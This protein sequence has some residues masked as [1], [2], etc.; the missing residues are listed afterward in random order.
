MSDNGPQFVSHVFKS[1]CEANG[2]KHTMVMPYHPQSNGTAER[3][4]QTV[5]QQTVGNET[6]AFG[7]HF[8]SVFPLTDILNGYV[9]NTAANIYV[10]LSSHQNNHLYIA[11][12]LHN[13]SMRCINEVFCY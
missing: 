9:T 4:V 12:F 6:V 8:A 13:V 5:T 11:C 2:I 1:F 7:L 3:C 10:P